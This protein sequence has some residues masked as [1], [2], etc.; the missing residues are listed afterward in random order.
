MRAESALSLT[1]DRLRLK[2][3]TANHL[4]D[5]FYPFFCPLFSEMTPVSDHN[6]FEK[7]RADKTIY[8]TYKMY[9]YAIERF[10]NE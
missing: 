4:L 3:A 10:I 9:F 5:C 7:L 8:V 6:P 1:L 2:P